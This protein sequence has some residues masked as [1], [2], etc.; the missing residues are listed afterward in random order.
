[1]VESIREADWTVV[2]DETGQA[3]D[4]CRVRERTVWQSD[5]LRTRVCPA[6][7]RLFGTDFGDPPAE[8]APETDRLPETPTPTESRTITTTRRRSG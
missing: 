6:C 8:R 1:V 3:C 2:E 4:W 5:V 7:G